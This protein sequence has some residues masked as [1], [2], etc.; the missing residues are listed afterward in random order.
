MP[1]GNVDDRYHDPASRQPDG[2]THSL[3]ALAR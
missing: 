1:V 3:A 2:S